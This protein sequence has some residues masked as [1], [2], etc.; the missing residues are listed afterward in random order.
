MNQTAA[1]IVSIIQIQGPDLLL[2]FGD[3]AEKLLCAVVYLVSNLDI[4]I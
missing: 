2:T 4:Y 3:A 1:K